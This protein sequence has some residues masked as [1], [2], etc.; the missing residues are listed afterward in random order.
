MEKNLPPRSLVPDT[1]SGFRH[2]E[3]WAGTYLLHIGLTRQANV[4]VGRL[5]RGEPIVFA[6]GEYVYVGSAMGKGNSFYLPKRLV[7]HAT[8]SGAQPAHAFRAH[9]LVHFA[10]ADL[11]PQQV[12]PAGPK[13]LFWNVDHLLD[14]A[15]VELRG[16]FYFCSDVRY[17]ESIASWLAS[18][19]NTEVPVPGFGA[20]DHPGHTHLFRLT[21]KDDAWCAL[22]R[23]L[24]HRFSTEGTLA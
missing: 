16:V 4:R 8:R 5:N 1:I 13:R 7:R 22:R 10:H 14:R 2:S 15:D 17:E 18:R 20:H 12:L 6:R 11:S 24:A 21:G 19:P 3:R 23:D 9:L